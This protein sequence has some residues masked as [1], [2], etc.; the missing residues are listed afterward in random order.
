MFSE[1]LEHP[2]SVFVMEGYIILDVDSHVV[3]VDLKPFIYKHICKDM[4]HE[5]V[6]GG[7]SIAESK[8]HDG[9]FEESHGSNESGFPL[10]FLP[11]VN[12]VISSV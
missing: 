5:S 2:S 11:D 7:G 10:I 12:V 4:V 3:H 8:E 9:V 1:L 6:E